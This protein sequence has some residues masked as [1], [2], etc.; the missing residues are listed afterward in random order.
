MDT[1]S[2]TARPALNTYEGLAKMIDHS[3]L[4]PELT[5]EQVLEGC[6]LAIRYNVA[7]VTV[8]PC[9]V[10]M[11]VRQ[12]QGTGVGVSTV[13]GFPHG[14]TTTAVKLYE[15]RDLLRRGAIEIDM[16]LNIS[17]L[18]SRQF[19]YVETEIRQAA[20]ACHEKGALLKVIFEN[21][22]LNDEL[23]IVACRICTR[24]EADFVKTS[25]GFAPTGATLEDLK[26]MRAHSGAKVQVKAAGGVRTMEKALEVYEVGCTRFG[27]TTTAAIL[28]N[29]KQHLAKL[30]S[31]D[32]APAQA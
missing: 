8:R 5:E 11:A 23:K 6:G 3:L 14:D 16:V 24:A 15:V 17:K 25:T 12:V 10:D 1:A 2:E 22:Y 7:T 32:S 9:D 20:E 31:A 29:W 26:L 18:I 21:A 19:Q 4:R 27:A 13:A 28:D 30:Q